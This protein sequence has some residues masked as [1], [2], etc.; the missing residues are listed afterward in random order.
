[1][2]HQTTHSLEAQVV[3]CHNVPITLLLQRGGAVYYNL[4]VCRKTTWHLPIFRRC[5]ACSAQVKFFQPSL[6]R[7]FFRQP[8]LQPLSPVVDG[9]FHRMPPVELV[10]LSG[11]FAA[12]P[13]VN[14][15]CQ[16][17]ACLAVLHLNFHP[18]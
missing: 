4:S 6:L 9:I 2:K 13:A 1:M 15:R 8:L 16:A 14:R 3:A 5:H 10:E 12:H 7:P 18:G 11:H 17:L